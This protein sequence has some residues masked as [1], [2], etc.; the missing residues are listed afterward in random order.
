VESTK[1]GSCAGAGSRFWQLNNSAP[2]LQ[3][4]PFCLSAGLTVRPPEQ[5]VYW[6]PPSPSKHASPLVWCLVLVF[7]SFVD[8]TRARPEF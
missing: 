3:L 6:Q 5:P 2:S 4:R 7:E 1:L 8:H